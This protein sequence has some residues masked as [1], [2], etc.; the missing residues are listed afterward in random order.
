MNYAANSF[1]A[2]DRRSGFD[3]RQGQLPIFSKYWLTGKRT[4]MRRK[5]DRK[6][7]YII[8]RH[9][10]KT[11]TAILLIIMLSVMDAV[12]TLDLV[13]RGATELNP[14]MAYYLGHSPLTFFI[15]KYLLTWAGVVLIL[16]NKNS[17]IFNTRIQVKFL[18][19][20]FIIPF[21]LV[22]QWELYL[23]FSI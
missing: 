16:L 11:V 10:P 8:D 15:V 22:V 6:R 19:I 1:S 12:L 21:A 4:V 3:R 2:F 17:F 14:V 7:P 23:L 9:S 13:S 18:F 20:A 5:E